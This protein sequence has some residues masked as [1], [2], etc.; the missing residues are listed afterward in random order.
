MLGGHSV[1]AFKLINNPHFV[2]AESADGRQA[3]ISV[4]RG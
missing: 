4:I 1:G 3:I 2:P